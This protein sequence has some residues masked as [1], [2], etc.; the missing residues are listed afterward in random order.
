MYR[1]LGRRK[2]DSVLYAT[3]TFLVKTQPPTRLKIGLRGIDR[4]K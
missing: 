3:D 1:E 4:G 2:C